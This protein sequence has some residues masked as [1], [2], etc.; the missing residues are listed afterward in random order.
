MYRFRGVTEASAIMA[1][2]VKV[3]SYYDPDVDGVIG[4]L[5]GQQFGKHKGFKTE[6]YLNDNRGHG[7][8]MPDHL[9]DQLVGYTVLAIDFNISKEQLISLTDRGINIINM[10]HH[11]IAYHDEFFYYES[12][13]S[14]AK[15][16]VI[17]NQYT[18]EPEEYRFLS[19]AGVAYYAFCA[20]D[21]TFENKDYEALVGITLLSDIREIEND[22]A[23]KIL[24]TTY[25]HRSP[26]FDYLIN[27][28]KP[29]TDFGFGEPIM[30]RNYVDFTFSPKIN[31]LLRLNKGHDAVALINQQSPHTNVDLEIIRRTQMSIATTIE[32]NLRGVT[33]ESLVLMCIPHTTVMPFNHSPA[34]F[35]GLAASSV[36]N[37]GKT[38]F[39]FI[40]QNGN[41]LR[42][43]VRGLLD[44]VDYLQIFKDHGFQCAG[45]KGAFGVW[46]TNITKVDINSLDRAVKAAEAQ[47]I[48]KIYEGRILDVNNLSLFLHGKNAEI[49][50]HN[51]YVRDVKRVLLNYTGSNVEVK[52]KGKMWEIHV[53]GVIVKNFK[54]DWN[55]SNCYI[56]PMIDRGK[57]IQFYLTK[58]I[59]Y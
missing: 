44:N 53:D 26:L 46:G 43:S 35:V 1:E 21:P 30:D 27:V 34:N 15:S 52:E 24:T 9:I 51:A 12:A 54:E 18:F 28:T 22:H 37:N 20:M 4:G 2:A 47:E 14:G 36:K 17:N 50:K 10:D 58:K 16:V 23:Y 7:F 59:E 31:A 13:I 49:A 29:T 6:Y 3:L 40:E 25:N 48:S 11:H 5:L 39:L 8:L 45:H 56:M 57:Y 38:T 33:G 41:V 32:E 55:L 42:G 19:G